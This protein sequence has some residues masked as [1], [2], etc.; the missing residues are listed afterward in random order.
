MK[1][2]HVP[3]CF[4]PDPIGGTE[5]FVA[6][7]MR[8]LQHLGVE[9]LAA[10]PSD[11]N[12]AY[13]IN[14][15]RVVRF[16]V[17]KISD[18]ADLYGIGDRAAAIEFA[19]IL[20][21]E[22][23]DI[24]HL[25]AFT[26][27]VSLRLV[28]EAKIREIPVVLT[29]HTPTV[30]CQRGTLLLWGEEFC[31]GRL[32]IHRCAGCTLNGLGMQRSLAVL[33]G[34][35]PPAAGHWLGKFGLEGGIWT[36]LRMS[37]LVSM[38]H[39]VFLQMASEIDHIVAVC[40]WALDLLLRNNLPAS[41]ISLSRQGISWGQDTSS[42]SQERWK[43]VRLA[44]VGRLDPTKGLHILV[45]AFRMVPNLDIRLDVYGVVQNS[46]NDAYLSRILALAAADPRIAFQG[47]IPSDDV[48]T[49][50]RHY[51]F[52]TVPSQWIETGP[53]VVLEAFAAGIP[54]IGWNLGGISEIV[55]HDV[56]GLLIEPGPVERWA[57]T[58]RHVAE[59]SVLRARLKAGVRPPRTSMN[60]AHEMLNLYNSLRHL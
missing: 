7:L 2:V 3:F 56:D 26:A 16:A 8:D 37:E 60:V 38:R 47:S 34:G 18:L 10:A 59:D 22:R 36:A 27:T 21:E 44:F 20:D 50:L 17:G 40:D 58:L 25:H 1:V 32:N 33:V 19:K 35:L 57:E 15:Q 31:D 28:R 12:R 5:V 9:V 51:D 23:P 4:A 43:G 13:T 52:L 55:R 24:L 54:V 6:Q 30:S 53:M 49:R 39:S 45:E 41:K 29:Y 11:I 48:V 14:D 42:S 46:A